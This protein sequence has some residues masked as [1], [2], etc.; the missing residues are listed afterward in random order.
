MKEKENIREEEEEEEKQD[1]KEFVIE[2]KEKVKKN[3]INGTEKE[4]A[5]VEK[6]N[7]WDVI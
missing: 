5:N 7:K 1:V 3:K 6:Q 2:V 4:K